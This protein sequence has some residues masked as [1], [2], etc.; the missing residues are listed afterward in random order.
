[1]ALFSTGTNTDKLDTGM[2]LVEGDTLR[3]TLG[4]A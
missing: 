2:T 3:W 1:M 4:I